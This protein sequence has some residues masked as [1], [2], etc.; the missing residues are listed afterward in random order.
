MS[1]I[2]QNHLI[3]CCAS[4]AAHADQIAAYVMVYQDKSGTMTY[5]RDGSGI[6]QLGMLGLMQT[7]IIRGMTHTG[8]SDGEPV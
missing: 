8:T 1:Y 7:G 6:N 3:D 4:M 5:H 2:D